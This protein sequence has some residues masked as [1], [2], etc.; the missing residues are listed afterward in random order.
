MKRLDGAPE[1]SACFGTWWG[2]RQSTVDS[3]LAADFCGL[4]GP[5]ALLRRARA[6]GRARYVILG[7]VCS[8][9]AR[10]RAGSHS[11]GRTRDESL[12]CVPGNPAGSAT[13]EVVEASS[14][15]LD[16]PPPIAL[17]RSARV[18]QGVHEAAICTGRIR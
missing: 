7:A 15:F 11:E 14:T 8:W 13:A 3:F 9:K 5:V 17:L 18:L 6:P 12:N 4:A 10:Y 16:M 2:S 1:K